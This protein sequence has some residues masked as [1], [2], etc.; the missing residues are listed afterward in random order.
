[1][2]YMEK[3]NV[4]CKEAN[5]KSIDLV[6]RIIPK[7]ESI[8]FLSEIEVFHE[9]IRKRPTQYSYPYTENNRNKIVIIKIPQDIENQIQVLARQGKKP[10]AMQQ[11]MDLTGI[12]LRAAKDYIDSLL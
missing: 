1:M 12:G 8:P 7:T 5:D 11:I 6:T 4:S 2:A 10:E 3:K 9:K